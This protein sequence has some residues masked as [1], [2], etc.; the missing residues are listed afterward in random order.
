MGLIFVGRLQKENIELQEENIELQ[1]R[2]DYWAK[3]CIEIADFGVALSNELKKYRSLGS[4][5]YLRKL[6]VADKNELARNYT[7][8]EVIE[9]N[10]P[11]RLGP[12]PIRKTE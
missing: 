7:P 11:I 6:V 9:Q 12:R 5:E 4:F 3:K 2:V 8:L 10:V 1:K